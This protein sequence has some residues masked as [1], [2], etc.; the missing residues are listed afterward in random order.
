MR[1]VVPVNFLLA[2]GLSVS[3]DGQIPFKIAPKSPD[4]PLYRIAFERKDPVAG[5]DAPPA[6]K[7][8]F[9]C[10]SDGTAFIAMLPAGGLVQTPL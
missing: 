1:R 2:T 4:A 6:F 5:I 7:L 9:D 3:A 8:P 10:T